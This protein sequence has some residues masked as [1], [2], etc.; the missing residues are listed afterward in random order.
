MTLGKKVALATAM[1]LGLA[2]AAEAQ[3]IIRL[4]NGTEIKVKITALTSQSVTY[5][6]GGGKVSTAKKED[7]VDITL[8]EPPP[9]LAKA[10]A[11]LAG[12]KY[13]GAINNYGQA[14]EEIG[15]KKA[16][17]LHKQFILFKIAQALFL[18]GSPNEALEKYRQIRN[19]GGDCWFRSDTFQR[20]LEIAKTKGGDAYE[21]ILKEMKGEPEPVGSQAELELAKIKFTAGDFDSA[22]ASFEKVASNPAS[23]FAGEAKLFSLR[24]L[25]GQKKMDELEGACKRILDDKGPNPPALLQAAGAW[26]SD[27]LLKKNEK[28]KTKWR[29][30]LMMCVQSIA[31]GPPSGKDEAEDYALALVIGAKCYV[32]MST[33]VEKPEAKEE[34]KSRAVNYYT[35][36]KRAYGKTSLAEVAQHELVAL[37]V[38]Q[39]KAAANSN[40]K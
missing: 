38:E 35:E 8:G 7:V 37:G 40:N 34:F 22:R 17:E 30:I 32:L 3:D 13:D 18:K 4:K 20:S 11:A 21:G 39:P 25:R 6:E 9:S 1:A 36:V 2:V 31:L 15:Q 27:I 14:L 26:M 29:D 16:R 33:A 24:S 12:G 10:D 28:D 19:E 5:S 23:P